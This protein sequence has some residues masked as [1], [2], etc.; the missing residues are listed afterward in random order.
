MGKGIIKGKDKGS[1]TA[2]IQG[3]L[4]EDAEIF[5][6]DEDKHNDNGL[7]RPDLMKMPGKE[8]AAL[9]LKHGKSD[10]TA[11]ALVKLGKPY[12]CDLLLLNESQAKDMN[13]K[14]RSRSK[15]ETESIVETVLDFVKE[16]MDIR[17]KKMVPLLEKVFRRTA[18]PFID[19]K[20][21]DNELSL[22]KINTF[23]LATSGLLI[24][25]DAIFG[26]RESG[27]YIKEN[28]RKRRKGNEHANK[29]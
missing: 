21:K 9:V 2:A 20:V 15:S 17:K 3:E 27:D 23:A 26:L 25:V 22:D 13:N 29:T 5:F 10:K 11:E 4:M 18:S 6:S 28:I 8:L 24:V 12:M 7:K 14:S 1:E 16:I 19:Q